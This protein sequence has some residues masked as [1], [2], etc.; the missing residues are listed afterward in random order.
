MC[1][2]GPGA[3]SSPGVSGSSGVLAWSMPAHGADGASAARGERAPARV[4]G[5]WGLEPGPGAGLGIVAGSPMA[6]EVVPS[7]RPEVLRSS[8]EELGL[9]NG[10]GCTHQGSSLRQRPSPGGTSLARG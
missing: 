4:V 1:Q 5:C 10:L 8:F 2:L 7:G 3:T 6:P 9:G